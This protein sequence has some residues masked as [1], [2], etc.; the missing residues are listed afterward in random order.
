MRHNNYK[1]PSLYSPRVTFPV[2]HHQKRTNI[3]GLTYTAI[4]PSMQRLTDE[5][6]G[7]TH[8]VR[9]LPYLP[10]QETG[11]ADVTW[12]ANAVKVNRPGMETSFWHLI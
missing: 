5:G 8:K 4:H 9:P 12:L 1:N 3:K 11:N 10:I 6:Y 2:R 7:V